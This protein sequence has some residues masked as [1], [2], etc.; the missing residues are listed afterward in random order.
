MI[1]EKDEFYDYILGISMEAYQFKLKVGLPRSKLND[2]NQTVL[3]SFRSC[4]KKEGI[5]YSYEGQS[6]KQP[7]TI[8]GQIVIK[9][10]IRGIKVPTP[11]TYIQPR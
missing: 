7:K 5:L 11:V 8:E 3:E 10:T 6:C 9:E 2:L 4:K 1:S